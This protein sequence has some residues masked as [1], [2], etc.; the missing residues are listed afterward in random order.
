ME[1]KNKT[2]LLALC[3][4]NLPFLLPALTHIQTESGFFSQ[5]ARST[6]CVQ[7]AHSISAFLRLHPNMREEEEKKK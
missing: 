2:E 1:G 5:K 3:G 7:R 6:V 4:L